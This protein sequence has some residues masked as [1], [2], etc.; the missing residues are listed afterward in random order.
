MS[1]VLPNLPFRTESL[2]PYTY[3][4]FVQIPTHIW[5]RLRGVVST[6][7]TNWGGDHP[8]RKLLKFHHGQPGKERNSMWQ[9]NWGKKSSIWS[10]FQGI[11]RRWLERFLK[12]LIRKWTASKQ[13]KIYSNAFCTVG[14]VLHCKPAV[15]FWAK[16]NVTVWLERVLLQHSVCASSF[17]SS[18]NITFEIDGLV[19]PD[20]DAYPTVVEIYSSRTH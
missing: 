4:V 6:S 2:S 5:V 1:L 7:G 11:C 20:V 18:S 12:I 19:N 9:W 10:H 15:K 14:W 13:Y 17:P 3:I 16:F 8:T